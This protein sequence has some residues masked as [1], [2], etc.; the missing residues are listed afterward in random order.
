[1]VVTVVGA[2]TT[3]LMYSGEADDEEEDDEY[4]DEYDGNTLDEES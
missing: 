1:M 4:Y 3:W 2:L